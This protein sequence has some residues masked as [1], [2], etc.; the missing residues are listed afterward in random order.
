[1]NKPQGAHR[2]RAGSRG[3]ASDVDTAEGI[4]RGETAALAKAYEQHSR[5]VFE[6][7]RGVLGQT[8]LAEEVVQDVFVTLWKQPERYDRER[9]S[10]RAYLST[11]AYG[12]SID[13][14]RSEAARRRREQRESRLTQRSNSSAPAEVD[15]ETAHEVRD[16]LMELRQDEREAIALAYFLGYSYREVAVELGVPEGT[17]KNRIRKGLSHLRDRLE[18]PSR[19][20]TP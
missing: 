14:A 19:V 17:I 15:V 5:A 12:R 9:G 4:A 20:G 6:V 11:V 10:L 13:L 7:A 16:A 1:M 18:S 3:D 8:L 2:A